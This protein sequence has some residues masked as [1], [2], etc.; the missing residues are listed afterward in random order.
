V[1]CPGPLIV[2]GYEGVPNI[3]PSIEGAW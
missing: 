2:G 3:D 1:G